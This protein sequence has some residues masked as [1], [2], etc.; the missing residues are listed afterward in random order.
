LLGSFRKVADPVADMFN[1][2]LICASEAR[3]PG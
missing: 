1:F 3:F 2:P